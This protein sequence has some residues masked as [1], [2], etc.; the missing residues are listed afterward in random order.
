MLITELELQTGVYDRL[1]AKG[2][3]KIIERYR[4]I[5][6]NLDVR[7]KPNPRTGILF[8]IRFLFQSTDVL[9]V[10]KMECVNIAVTFHLDVHILRCILR[11]TRTQSVETECVVIRVVLAAR[12]QLTEDKLPVIAL[13]F[14]VVVYRNA[15][16]EILHFNRVVL[17]ACYEHLRA[18]AGARFIH[19]VGQNFKHRVLTSLQP[20]GTKHNARTF[21]N[22]IR[23]FQSG[24]TFVIINRLLACHRHIF[25]LSQD[26]VYQLLILTHILR[27]CQGLK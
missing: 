25:L 18:V 3:V 26:T 11:R 20:I 4:D 21:A 10:L 8:G 27:F 7:L 17:I 13:L 15:A 5:G 9:A 12:V 22:T 14:L 2:V 24:N 23:A 19:R 1:T 16:A 6:K